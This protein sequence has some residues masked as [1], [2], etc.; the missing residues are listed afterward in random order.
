MKDQASNEAEDS[1][2]E[3]KEMDAEDYAESDWDEL[4]DQE[5]S[6]RLAAMVLEDDPDDLDWVP[7]KVCSKQTTMKKGNKI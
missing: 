4:K 7:A 6:E 2:S 1:D 5:F 3:G